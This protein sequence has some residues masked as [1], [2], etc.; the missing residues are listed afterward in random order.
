MYAIT[1]F[2]ARRRD[3][4]ARRG[5]GERIRKLR[6]ERLL[7]QADLAAQAGNDLSQTDIS[8]IEGGSRWPSVP[9]LAAIYVALGLDP[10]PVLAPRKGRRTATPQRSAA[11]VV[12]RE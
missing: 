11:H 1:A 5:L 3:D 4:E 9:Q 10:E 6:K 7:S 2:V 12:V 8:K